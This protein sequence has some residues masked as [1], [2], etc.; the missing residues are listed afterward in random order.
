M[1]WSALSKFGK[2]DILVNNAGFTAPMSI[3]QI[4][5]DDFERTIAVNLYAP[6]TIVLAFTV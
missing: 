2:V 5:F 3:Q 4:A 6:F 1:L